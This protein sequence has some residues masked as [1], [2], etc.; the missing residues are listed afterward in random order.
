APPEPVA[1]IALEAALAALRD[2]GAVSAGAVERF[3][4][5][6]VNWLVEDVLKPVALE[7]DPERLVQGAF[8]HSVLEL[9]YR[10]LREQT[11]DRRVTEANLGR[12][13]TIMLAALA[14]EV[15]RRGAVM[16]GPRM[17][18]A[19]RRLEFQ[20]LRHL[21]YEARSTSRFEPEHLELAFGLPDAEHPE[22]ELDDGLRVRGKIDRVDRFGDKV[23]V[24]DYKSGR[25]TDYSAA[26]WERKG[27]LQAALYMLVAERLLGAEAVAGLYA[28]LSGEERRPRGAVSAAFADELGGDFYATDVLSDEE[29]AELREWARGAIATAAAEMGEGKLCSKPDSCAYR[30]GCSHPSIC[31]IER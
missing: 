22:V 15:E 11:G 8:A 4:G 19:V 10:R 12:A 6:P 18:A 29:L 30:G 7:P 23:A 28:P 17:R 2:R 3:A 26:S 16:R 9:T 1:P 24:R 14:E 27:R 20:L 21:A 13:E 5:C 31:R 25:V